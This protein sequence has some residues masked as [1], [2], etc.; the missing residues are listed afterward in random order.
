[1]SDLEK[2]LSRLEKRVSNYRSEV[3]TTI[4]ALTDGNSPE[5]IQLQ[6]NVSFLEKEI[7][8]LRSMLVATHTTAP[9]NVDSPKAQKKPRQRG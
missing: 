2:K 6:K 9:K 1:M 8:E 3:E 7:A 4:A 5:A